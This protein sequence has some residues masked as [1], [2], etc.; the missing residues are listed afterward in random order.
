MAHSLA[1]AVVP[2]ILAVGWDKVAPPTV[3]SP[4]DGDFYPLL[5]WP[6]HKLAHWAA[7][8]ARVV[9]W[10]QRNEMASPQMNG[11]AHRTP[12]RRV[13]SNGEVLEQPPLV[14][15]QFDENY[16]PAVQS[17][18]ASQR[19]YCRV[20]GCQWRAV[21][22]TKKGRHQDTADFL[23]ARHPSWHKV[24]ILR[25][26]LHHHRFVAWID[27]DA[28]IVNT[29]VSFVQYFDNAPPEVGVVISRDMGYSLSDHRKLGS[30]MINTGVILAR[31]S[32]WTM[33]YLDEL[34]HA[35]EYT[36]YYHAVNPEQVAMR[37]EL[38]R[39]PQH[40][41]VLDDGL[42]Q[43]RHDSRGGSATKEEVA[44]FVR[45]GGFVYHTMGGLAAKAQ[46]MVGVGSGGR[47]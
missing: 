43:W 3:Q 37:V 28:L 2:Y 16:A 13:R 14:V 5:Q 38:C 45:R 31:R 20:Q 25:Q 42:L 17:I 9:Q 29:N 35:V 21:N 41:K 33:R 32:A 34:L 7:A 23:R 39:A 11:P 8:R 10:R 30:L 1:A 4:C 44:A 22:I 47:G 36:K 24:L 6:P 12:D 40:F 27:S 46:D 18:S 19:E 26:A 15:T